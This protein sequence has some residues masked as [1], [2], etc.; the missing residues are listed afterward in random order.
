[1][2]RPSGPW[3]HRVVGLG[4][5]TM[6]L[7]MPPFFSAKVCVFLVRENTVFLNLACGKLKGLGD[8]MCTLKTL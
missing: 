1:M 4:L 3:A 5:K 8:L 2:T 6:L 7:T